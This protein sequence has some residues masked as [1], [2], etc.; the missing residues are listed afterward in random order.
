MKRVD[1]PVSRRFRSDRACPKSWAVVRV[2]LMGP[3]ASVAVVVGMTAT[4]FF[5][6]RSEDRRDSSPM[7]RP[8]IV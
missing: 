8:L 7:I 5:V 6:A 4:A 3:F 2:R 1:R